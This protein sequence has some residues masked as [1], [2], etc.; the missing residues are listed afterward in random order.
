MLYLLRRNRNF[1]AFS[2][3][4]TGGFVFFLFV[5]F[6]ILKINL[7]LFV[8]MHCM[9][10][11]TGTSNSS[12]KGIEILEINLKLNCTVIITSTSHYS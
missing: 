7:K 2:E 12:V 9:A 11:T 10:N 6:K 8:D 1:R 4:K 3:L 5:C